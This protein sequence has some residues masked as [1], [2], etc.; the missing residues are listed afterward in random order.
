VQ[1]HDCVRAVEV[2]SGTRTS[3]ETGHGI[4]ADQPRR[5]LQAVL[6]T[7]PVLRVFEHVPADGIAAYN[8]TSRSQRRQRIL[9]HV[10]S[11]PSDTGCRP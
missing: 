3:E 8:V 7:Q 9:V 4:A 1:N 6:E 2:D 11:R 10:V 5:S